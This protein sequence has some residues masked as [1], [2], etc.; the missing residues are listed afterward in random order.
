M[1]RFILKIF[2]ITIISINSAFAQVNIS[3]GNSGVSHE[4]T[5]HIGDTIHFNFWIINQSNSILTDSL[6]IECETFDFNNNSISSMSIGEYYNTN[7]S[8]DVGDSLSV[9]ISEVVTYASYV[10]GDNIIVIWPAF[11]NANGIMD[12]SFTNIHI[13][14]SVSTSVKLIEDLELLLFPNPNNGSFKIEIKQHSMMESLY[15]FDKK[16]SIIFSD[17]NIIRPQVIFRKHL[18]KGIYF[19]KVK[20]GN[21]YYIKNVVVE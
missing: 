10:L 12:T 15:I 19:V 1:L 11:L 18:K 8:L 21:D 17:Y 4:D 5:L 14:D 7:L 2:L 3:F 20:I 13:L 9:S 16:G 6:S